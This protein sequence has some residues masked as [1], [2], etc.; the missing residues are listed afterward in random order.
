MKSGKGKWRASG[1]TRLNFWRYES[2]G[3]PL[4]RLLPHQICS[5]TC[6]PRPAPPPGVDGVTISIDLLS[7]WGDDEEFGLTEIQIYDAKGK[8]IILRADALSVEGSAE[9]TG[10]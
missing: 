6:I 1:A 3:N 9:E 10:L 2:S 7:S 5:L 4:I 8:W